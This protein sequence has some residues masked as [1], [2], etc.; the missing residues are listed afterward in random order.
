MTAPTI[1]VA[2]ATYNGATYLRSQLDSLVAQTRV[3]AELVITDDGSTDSTR[4]IV[5]E[6]AATAPFPVH[7]RPNPTRL[8]FRAN[9]MRA[10]GLCTGGLIAF[11]DQDDIWYS[12]KLADV[13]ALFD[14]DPDTL[15]VH[16]NARIL[17]SDG[18]RTDG[19]LSSPTRHPSTAAPLTLDPWLDS[20]GF[21]QT[22]RR[23]L[24]GFQ[25]LWE[26]SIDAST[27]AV[28][29]PMTHDQWY[30]FVAS[31]FGRVGWIAP[32][33][34]DY[35]QHGRNTLG[36][37]PPPTAGRRL[38][39]WLEDRSAVY[40][41]CSEAAARRAE[42]LDTASTRVEDPGWRARAVTAGIRYRALAA[43]YASR[44]Q[45]YVASNLFR[46]LGA[47]HALLA[48]NAYN[49]RGDWTFRAK[50]ACKDLVLGAIGGPVLL[51]Y[52]YPPE[53]GDGNCGAVTHE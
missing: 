35:R 11:C 27:P 47:F 9:F 44:H 38:R 13:C 23:E 34:A 7:F 36:W 14:N 12:T 16:H 53:W 3:P 32:P 24:L 18:Q 26:R 4:M 43:L 6:F 50:G 45:V 25:D 29:Q 15:L 22:F 2:L 48:A 5:E 21:T 31:V 51:R 1:S 52:G 42:L 37:S 30:L 8:G 28:R 17:N 10:A 46:R 39:L 20:H 49:H 40:S 19:L 41:R 33:L